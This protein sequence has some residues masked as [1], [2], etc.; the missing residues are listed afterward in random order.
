MADILEHPNLSFT[1]AECGNSYDKERSDAEAFSE[2]ETKF[3]MSVSKET[4]TIVCEDCFK[5]MF[6]N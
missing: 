2:S 1:C 5:K 3:G 6:D 4:H